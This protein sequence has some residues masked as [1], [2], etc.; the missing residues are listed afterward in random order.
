MLEKYVNERGWGLSPEHVYV[1]DG[2][3]GIDYERPAFQRLIR[4][5]ESGIINCVVTKDLSRLGR[6]HIETSRLTE[7]YFPSKGVRYIAVNDGVDTATE[8]SSNDFMSLRSVINDWYC[9]DISKKV[10]S[11]KRTLAAQGKFANSRA[12]YG[13]IKAPDNRHQLIVDLNVADIV[14]RIYR[15]F[16]SGYSGRHIAGIFNRESIPTPN[17]Y[18]YASE[19]RP[20]PRNQSGKW[21]S[22]VVMKIL[23][24]PVYKGTMAQGRR[25][26][27]SYKDKTAVSISPDAWIVVD[28]TH[29]AIID[30]VTWEKAQALAEKNH[31]GIRR[32]S[33]GE[34]N[35]FSGIVRC[36]DC[37]TKMTYNRKV[38]A[39]YTKEYYRCGRYTNKGTDACNPH[40]IIFQTVYDAV[41]A[42]LREYARLAASDEEKL[43][44]RLIKS[45]IKLKESGIQQ[46]E[47]LLYSKERRVK[48]IDNLI[49]ALFEDK[50][51]GNVPDGVFKR[52]AQKYDE[53]QLTLTGEIDRLRIELVEQRQNE[54]DISGWV[55]K[56]KRC[57]SIETLTR[58]IAMELIDSIEISEA[59]TDDNGVE[60]QDIK[61]TY[62]FEDVINKEKRAS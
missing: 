10:R 37:G 19:G 48:E 16:L 13:Y 23:K 46:K 21:G 6:E 25:K 1:D 51:K 14:K 60:Q 8:T 55:E 29:E 5:I 42:D 30:P 53:E 38:F 15:L 56:I 24:N 32:N 34:V 4:N 58:E 28:G 61:I 54:K 52:M 27:A 43:I 47:K 44:N 11:T 20:N 62:R 22:G 45:N 18:F 39:S 31:L 2:Y 36:A 41:L 49:Q 9:R 17:T 26:L 40:T 3:T 35:I 7:I 50:V 59:Y 57:L 12:P 33:T